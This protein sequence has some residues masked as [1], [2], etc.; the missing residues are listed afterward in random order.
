MNLRNILIVM[1]TGIFVVA[2]ASDAEAVNKTIVSK[3]K[4]MYDNETITD[5]SDDVII[6]DAYDLIQLEQK[7]DAFAERL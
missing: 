5:F 6:F 4:I 3:G 1:I 7:I 2:Y